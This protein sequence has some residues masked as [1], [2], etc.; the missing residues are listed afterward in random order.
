MVVAGKDTTTPRITNGGVSRTSPM[1]D[2]IVTVTKNNNNQE[3]KE[4]KKERKKKGKS[5]EKGL[6]VGFPEHL[7]YPLEGLGFWDG[8]GAVESISRYTGVTVS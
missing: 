8:V 1:V 3:R 4:R 7:T 2:A 6:M 5:E